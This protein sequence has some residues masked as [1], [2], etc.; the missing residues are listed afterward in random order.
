[1][2]IGPLSANRAALLGRDRRPR[3]DGGTELYSTLEAAARQ[4]QAEFDPTKINGIILLS[5][6]GNEDP[7][8]NDA[9]RDPRRR[10]AGT[11]P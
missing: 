7:S 10:T 6:G 11:R 5:D 3:G 4:M 8:N 1:M 2:P 9:R